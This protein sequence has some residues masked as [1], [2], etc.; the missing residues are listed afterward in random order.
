MIVEKFVLTTLLMTASFGLYAKNGF[1]VVCDAFNSLS[2]ESN[3]NSLSPA[4]KDAYILKR[5]KILDESSSARVAY[6]ALR[7]FYPKT[8]RYSMFV[9]SAAST[10]INNWSCPAMMQLDAEIDTPS[11]QVEHIQGIPKGVVTMKTG[12]F[13]S[14]SKN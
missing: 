10:G 2:K 1:D 13:G 6:I 9:E 14:T 4:Q 5:I 7:N 12:D 8:Q 11:N 3:V